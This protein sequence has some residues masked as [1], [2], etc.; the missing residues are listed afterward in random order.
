MAKFNYY[1]FSHEEDNKLLNKNRIVAIDCD[2]DGLSKSK[3]NLIAI[4]AIEIIDKRITGKYFHA[5]INKRKH[6]GDFMNY[7]A[8][9]NYNI[10]IK[11]KISTFLNFVSKSTIVSHNIEFDIGFIN[12]EIEKIDKNKTIDSKKCICTMKIMRNYLRYYSLF[13][14][15]IFYDIAVKDFHYHKGIVDV[16]ILGRMICKM[17]ENS[18]KNYNV[19][20]Y[21]KKYMKKCLKKDFIIEY[22]QNKKDTYKNESKNILTSD[23]KKDTNKNESKKVLTSDSK[24]NTNKNESKKVKNESRKVTNKNENK[25]KIEA[26]SLN[27]NNKNIVYITAKGQCY[28]IRPNCRGTKNMMPYD[29]SLAEASKRRKCKICYNNAS[30][31]EFDE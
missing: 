30:T 22:R 28:H 14:S 20:N 3:N 13:H 17:V 31:T 8:E 25:L 6:E 9:Y 15:A 10:P 7:L 24:K 27:T 29:L 16:T 2:T 18:G 5:F 26:D 1:L 21:M 4:H 23:S 12:A 11:K 19:D